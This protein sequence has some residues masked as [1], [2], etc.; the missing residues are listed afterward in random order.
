MRSP[1]LASPASSAVIV[2]GCHREMEQWHPNG[3]LRQELSVRT[4]RTENYMYTYSICL[5]IPPLELSRISNIQL[6]AMLHFNLLLMIIQ[7]TS[8]LRFKH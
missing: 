3:N 5:F 6:L 7:I 4:V 8:T 1:G 2:I